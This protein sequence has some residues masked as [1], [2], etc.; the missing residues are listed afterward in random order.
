[1]KLPLLLV[2]ALVLG[3]QTRPPL[4]GMAPLFEMPLRDPS[5]AVGPD[6]AYYLTGTSG[7]PTWWKT[8]E[9]I[10]V[11]KSRD[12]KRW[13]LLGLVWTFEKNATWQKEVKDG[14]RAIWAPEI[15]YLKGTFWL[16]YCVNW[17]TGG[18]G[19][20]KSTSG[21]A[22]GPYVDIKP[23][24]PLTPEIDASLFQDDDGKVYFVFQ[25]GKIA[26]MNDDMS[27]LAEEPHLLVPANRKEV[28]FEGAFIFKRDKRYYL[29]AAEFNPI[30]GDPE[31]RKTYD[32]MAAC[33]DLLSGPYGDAYLAIPHGGHNMIFRD[34]KGQWRSTFFGNDHP[35]PFRE[36]FGILPVEFGADGRIRPKVE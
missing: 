2:L 30:P 11:W 14:R 4:P 35:A 36:R 23:D 12:L 5:I 22:E 20:L 17:K 28:G 32:C 27:G 26:R 13:T 15:H 31:K 34:E 19:I 9:G 24:G 29:I 16:T 21:K 6:G 33:S 7:Y 1:M 10:R 3:Q 18:T 8:N 25:N